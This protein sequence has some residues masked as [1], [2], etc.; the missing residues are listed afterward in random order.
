MSTE[1]TDDDLEAAFAREAPF[2]ERGPKARAQRERNMRS[3][4]S[5]KHHPRHKGDRVQFN[6]KLARSLHEKVAAA[7]K[8]HGINETDALEQ[9]LQL[10]LASTGKKNV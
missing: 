5:E 7:C 8:R 3:P 2:V 4:Y 6:R 9:A 1:P 10:W